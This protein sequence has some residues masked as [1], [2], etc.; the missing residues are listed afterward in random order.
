MPG[1][2]QGFTVFIH[3]RPA[4]SAPLF[5]GPQRS[6]VARSA[7]PSPVS[8]GCTMTAATTSPAGTS[9]ELR[10]GL[11]QVLLATLASTIAFWAWMSISPLQKTYATEMGLDEGQIS[12]MLATPVL[13]GALGRI[14]VGAMTDRFGG[15]KM[16]TA[17][18]LISVPAVLLVALAGSIRSFPLLLI[19][20]FYLGVAGTIFAVGVPFASAWYLPAHRGL[21]NGIF[22][23]G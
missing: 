10:G 15:R 12:L 9:T 6:Q 5:S 19:A 18:L 8:K 2:L 4:T 7:L 3:F 11:G 17:V 1:P 13:V 14:L 20:G 21:A 16:F 23:M 22:G